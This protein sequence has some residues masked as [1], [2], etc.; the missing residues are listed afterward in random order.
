MQVEFSVLMGQPPLHVKLQFLYE[1]TMCNHACDL[2]SEKS[3]GCY[4]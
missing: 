1:R 4:I 2:F 3:H